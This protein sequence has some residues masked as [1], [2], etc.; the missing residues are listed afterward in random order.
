[1]DDE[2]KAVLAALEKHNDNRAA[3]VA[4]LKLTDSSLRQR[5][6]AAAERGL[7]GTSPQI[8]AASPSGTSRHSKR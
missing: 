7:L 3:T 6:V 8:Q 2:I 4:D 5:I 1:M